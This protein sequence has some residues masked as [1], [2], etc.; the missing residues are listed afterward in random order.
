MREL[1]CLR[2]KGKTQAVRIDQVF[3]PDEQPPAAALEHFQIGRERLLRADWQ[4]ARA[5]FRAARGQGSD[6]VA[7]DLFLQRCDQLQAQPPPDDWDG[8]WPVR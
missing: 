3:G 2:V 6:D 8:G 1:D 5:A 7:I 4:G